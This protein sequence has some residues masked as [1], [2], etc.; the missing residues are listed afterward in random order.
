LNAGLVGAAGAGAEAAGKGA[1]AFE[2]CEELL[3]EVSGY[4]GGSGYAAGGGTCSST[5]T[6]V[7]FFFP[8][9]P[10][11]RNPQRPIV[12]RCKNNRTETIGISTMQIP[13]VK[14]KF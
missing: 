8:K 13:F 11:D 6:V 1:G 7:S 3:P 9:Q 5:A 12:E 4:L 10:T 2:A 14:V